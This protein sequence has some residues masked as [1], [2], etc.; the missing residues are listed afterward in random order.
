MHLTS[1]SGPYKPPMQYSTLCCVSGDQMQKASRGPW[2]PRECVTGLKKPGSLNH[3][4]VGHLPY[5]LIE[6]MCE[7]DLNLCVKPLRF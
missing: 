6:L 7:Y 1:G 2:G 4:V 3:P 5:I